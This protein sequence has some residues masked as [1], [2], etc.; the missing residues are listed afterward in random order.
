MLHPY[1]VFAVGVLGIACAGLFVRWAQ[2][3]PPV[4]VGFYRM[5]I[6]SSLLLAVLAARRLLARGR[7]SA[8]PAPARAV[9]LALLAGLSFGTD[10]AL[11]HHAL[12]RTSVANAT[13]LVNTTPIH[14]GL[15]TAL[16]LREPLGRGF[17][18]GATLALLGAVALLGIEVGDERAL[19]GDALALGAAVFYTGY[20]LAMT[21]A[22]EAIDA[23]TAITCMSL[24]AA[25]V[26]GAYG[27]ALGDAF[28]GFPTVS[29]LAIAACAVVSQLVGAFS[30]V[31]A[32]RFMPPP[33]T[34]VALIAQPVV[35][36]GL[37]WWWLGEPIGVL[38]G[39]GALGVL[40]GI[41]L[42]SRDAR[43]RA[44]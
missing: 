13:L 6:A 23:L 9:G 22:R 7:R 15:F 44:G 10:I 40:A 17:V 4:V 1:W 26:L 8:G 28:Q 36:A 32:V 2:P 14:V 37:A 35:A 16:V 20:I 29:W 18:A 42:V 30:I 33:F 3:A 31:W 5:A 27:V 11:W 41:L 39:L 24:S 38:Q 21:R 34:S 12:V 25:L 43:R 19:R